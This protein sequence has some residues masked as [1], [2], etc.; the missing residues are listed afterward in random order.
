[1]TVFNPSW[2]LTVAGTDYT[3]IAISDIA[4]QAGRTDIYSQP[5]PSYMQIS[6]ISTDGTTLPF[7]INDSLA[8][9]IKN[10]SNTYVNLFGGDITD[11]TVEVQAT[12]SI[13]TVINYTILAMGS[14]AKLAKQIYNS[15]ISQDEDGNQIYTLLSSVLLGKWTDVPAASTWA[16]Y[17]A[18]ETWANAVN[19]G[20]GEIDT[21]GLYTMEN[22]DASP[23]T[24]YNIAGLIA[25]SAFGYLYEDNSGN[26][27][28]AD[29]DHRQTYLLANGYTDLTANDALGSGLRTTTRSGDIR[30]DVYV[31]YGNSYGSQKTAISTASI[32]LY[33]YKSESLNTTLHSAVDAQAV[34]DRYIAQRAYPYPVFDSIT[35]PMTSPELSDANRDALLGVFMGMPVNIQNLPIQ[36]SGGQFEGYV[37]G[38]RWSTGYKELFL[39]INVSP[40]S[41]SQVAMRWNT[42]PVG[43]AWNTLSAILTWENATIVA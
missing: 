21:P 4:H 10:S 19:L 40:V 7:A 29:A 17:S 1:M 16:T 2:K 24:I 33:G 28:Y 42:V 34:A 6:L 23:D 25:N 8:L 22:R 31:N 32:A 12:G 5:A 38:W 13:G 37:E 11:L 9:Q 20:L 14:L 43:E 18:T 36:I 15:T 41:F 27:G 26:I 30:N 39:T 35:F 3:N